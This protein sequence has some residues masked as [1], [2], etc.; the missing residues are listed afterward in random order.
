[1][2]NSLSRIIKYKKKTVTFVLEKKLIQINYRKHCDSL[3]PSL[4]EYQSSHSI[5]MS[6]FDFCIVKEI[7]L[8]K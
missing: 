7:N 8:C 4:Y 2:Q 5:F 3:T 6:I 1:M